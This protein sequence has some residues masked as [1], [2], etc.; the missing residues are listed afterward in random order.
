[1]DA[2]LD[3][4]RALQRERVGRPPD[5]GRA[6]RGRMRWFRLAL[7]VCRSRGS[8]RYG[9][10]SSAPCGGTV[11]GPVG[12]FS[13]KRPQGVWRSVH[14]VHWTAFRALEP[15]R[16]RAFGGFAY[17]VPHPPLRG[18]FPTAVGKLLEAIFLPSPMGKVDF[19]EI[20]CNFAERRMRSPVRR[21]LR[22]CSGI[23]AVPNVRDLIRPFGAPSP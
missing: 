9:D 11:R 2:S 3:A 6:Q 5:G 10:T 7:I 4:L 1:M 12:P 15:P 21:V 17:W 20:A 18:Y 19:G 8:E 13:L 23:G 22:L 16:G 14:A